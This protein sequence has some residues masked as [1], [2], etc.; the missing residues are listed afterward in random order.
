[1]EKRYCEVCG[2]EIPFTVINKYYYS[3]VKLC[4]DRSC[5]IMHRI[6]HYERFMEKRK[7]TEI[8]VDGGYELMVAM[9]QSCFSFIEVPYEEMD[10]RYKYDMNFFKSKEFNVLVDCFDC[11]KLRNVDKL[12]KQYELTF[13]SAKD[14]KRQQKENRDMARMR[15]GKECNCY[16]LGPGER[17]D[18]PYHHYEEC[19]IQLDKE[20]D[21]KVAE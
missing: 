13:S 5:H 1:M 11:E 4:G 12:I 20:G 7:I 21:T 2:E 14:L 10:D 16:P 15:N 6:K 17:T 9:L 8:D 19:G 18:C 3:K